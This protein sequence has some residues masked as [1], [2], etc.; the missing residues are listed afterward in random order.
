MK[1]TFLALVEL[2]TEK[3]EIHCKQTILKTKLM[4]FCSSAGYCAKGQ[5]TRGHAL[6][7]EIP[8]R[9]FKFFNLIFASAEWR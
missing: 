6:G 2:K 3:G 7:L 8:Q 5:L 4:T 9:L 1:Y